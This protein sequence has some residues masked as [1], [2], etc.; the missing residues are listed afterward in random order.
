V[1]QLEK[2]LSN[3]SFVDNAPEPVVEEE[4]QKLEEATQKLTALQEQ[5][6]ML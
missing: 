1:I 3:S 4:K 5:L 2:K 6:S